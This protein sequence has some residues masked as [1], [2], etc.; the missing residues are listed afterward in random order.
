MDRRW[1]YLYIIPLLLAFIAFSVTQQIILMAA[2]FGVGL[3][4]MQLLRSRLLPPY[5]HKA[6]RQFQHGDLEEATDL[7]NKAI[8]AR[9][10]RWESYYLRSLISFAQTNL[11]QAEKDAQQAIQLNPKVH[12]TY[13]ALGQVYYA[14][15]NF[16]QAKEAFTQA[17]TRLSKQA[18]NQYHVGTA[19]YRLQEYDQAIPRL[20]LATKLGLDNPQ[21]YL[22]AFYYLARSLEAQGHTEDAQIAYSEMAQYTSALEGL[23]QDTQHVAHFPALTL[24]KQDIQAIQ[25]RLSTAK[26]EIGD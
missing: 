24:L 19:H 16:Q 17:V 1:N 3:L 6:V 15:T 20:E 22:L 11:D 25:L 9:P 5:L 14:Q 2:A 21:L 18:S 8:T 12:T 4:I 10:E 13:I 23:Q 7:V 26:R